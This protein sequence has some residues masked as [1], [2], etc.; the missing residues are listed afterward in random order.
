M[1]INYSFQVG[2]ASAWKAIQ[3]IKNPYSFPK[4]D[5]QVN[6]ESH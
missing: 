5:K 3:F 6:D 2:S 1:V 4:I